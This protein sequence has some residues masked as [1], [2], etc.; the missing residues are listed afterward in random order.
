MSFGS[1]IPKHEEY[2]ELKDTPY[3]TSLRDLSQRGYEGYR[4]NYNKVNVFSPETQRSLDDYT[5]AVYKRAEGDFDRQYRDTMKRMANRNYG[6]F[7]TLNATPALYRTD[8]EN[9]AQQ[10]K[11]ADMA[12]NKALYRESLV[13]NELRRRYNT[14]NMYNEMLEKGQT[15]YQLDLKNWEIRNKNKDVRFGNAEIDANAGGGFKGALKGAL[16]GAATGFLLAGG[17]LSALAGA[18]AGGFLGAQKKYVPSSI[19]SSTKVPDDL[20]YFGSNVGDYVGGLFTALGKGN[21]K[22]TTTSSGGNGSLWDILLQETGGNTQL[23]STIYDDIYTPTTTTPLDDYSLSS[24]L[25]SYLGGGLG[26]PTT[27]NFGR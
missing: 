5:N 19:F 7:G 15:P 13:D 12:Y 1:K 9:L 22:P 18:A 8:M 26:M 11:L 27:I 10:R 6:Q 4:D 21:T 2:E 3:I 24:V 23:P 20:G 16:Q 14:L 17:P 25:N